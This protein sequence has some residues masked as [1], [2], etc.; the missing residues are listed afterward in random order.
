[1][2]KIKVILAAI[3]FLCVTV[4]FAACG[5]GQRIATPANLY[6]DENDNLNWSE[7]AGARTYDV[8]IVAIDGMRTERSTR[9][10]SVSLVSL[11]EGD[12]DI[13]V[14]AVTGAGNNSEWSSALS[15]KKLPDAGYSYRALDDNT[16]WELSSARSSSGDVVIEDYYRGKPIIGIADGAF[17]N[18]DR[19]T[20]VQVGRLVR[21]LGE[22][23][24]YNCTSLVSVFLPESLLSIGESSFHGCTMLKE[25][26]LPSAL[27]S[28]PAFTYAYCSS[29]ETV[30]IS[31]QVK[32][33]GESAFYSCT[34]LK[35]IVIPD[36]V[37]TI[38][39]YAFARNVTLVSVRFGAGLKTVAQ[40]A[41]LR[42]S[43]LASLTF[44][45]AYSSLEFGRGIFAECTSLQSAELP[46]GLNALPVSCFEADT[47]L[48]DVTIPE[49]VKSVGQYA[50]Y[51]TALLTS[52]TEDAYV[53]QWLIS[54]P[55]EKRA[56][57]VQ[58]VPGDF[59]EDII[60]IGDAAFATTQGGGNPELTQVTFPASL[61]Y[62]GNNAFYGCT[63]LWK[64]DTAPQSQLEVVGQSAFR[65]CE[66]LRNIQFGESSLVSIEDYA[67][68][69]CSNLS[70]P[71]DRTALVPATVTHIGQGVFYETSLYRNANAAGSGSTDGLVYAGHWIVGYD[72]NLSA[73]SI[74]I[75]DTEAVGIADYALAANTM[76]QTIDG[77]SHIRYIG[78][79]AFYNCSNLMSLTL[80]R[81]LTEIKPYTFFQ[82]LALSSVGN[83]MPPFLSSI[84]DYAFFQCDSLTSLDLTGTEV[85]EIGTFAFYSCA[86]S[87]IV[88]N[89]GLEKIDRGAF[90]HNLM[91]ELEIPAT[92]VSIGD[93]A[94]TN[95]SN[96]ETLTFNEGLVDIG[97]YAFGYSPK[98]KEIKLPDSVVTVGDG[99][100]F[101]C[102]TV[103]TLILGS[104]L[105]SIGNWAFGQLFG[106]KSLV[107]PAGLHSVGDYAFMCCIGLDCIVLPE[108][109]EYLGSYAFYGC[110]GA[111]F[112]TELPSL[113]E[114]WSAR[115]NPSYR[116]V[117]W[118]ATLSDEG[119]VYSVTTDHITD[120][121]A[122]GGVSAP[123]RA[124]YVFLGW[125]TTEHATEAEYTQE[126][127][128][129]LPAGLT[130][131]AV[132]A[133]ASEINQ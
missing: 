111:T 124:G 106:I 102:Y 72:R 132:Y 123:E 117:L 56:A 93:Y 31:D 118:G 43:A 103:E 46:D 71:T 8:E 88:L 104:G 131:Y 101:N 47:A 94:F 115:W 19:V 53:G 18:D 13:R 116:P 44:A 7:V 100:F 33:I 52:Q 80:S 85:K 91:S 55:A 26:N 128:L 83:S 126:E 49:S 96:L 58:L 61:R 108:G 65:N 29:L 68:M 110:V 15:F 66:T 69:G 40:Y 23:V 86:L 42:D 63:K 62:I 122:R 37:E 10:A 133:P 48:D 41:F 125:S 57:L 16:A 59:H 120:A 64:I 21:K 24:F 36:S 77:T 38:G 17:R 87:Q 4:F 9:R 82:C 113:P 81:N 74:T 39:E 51:G 97:R 1:M 11:A 114:T 84:G 45:D 2:K 32:S 20:S 73:R 112:Y 5:K 95:S 22:R 79:G 107:L 35:E 121:T 129:A 54:V 78:E 30:T 92:V 60:G 105:K 27:D 67:F 3:L 90:Y 34:S 98:L 109:L 75:S 28:I 50:F 70:N 127:I 6:I 130:L 14:R 12:Y 89:S 99:V 25:A 76:L 119:Y